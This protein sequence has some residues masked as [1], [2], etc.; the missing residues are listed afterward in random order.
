VAGIWPNLAAE[1]A[2]RARGFELIAGVDEAGRG[3]LA[4]PVVAAAVLLPL[5]EPVRVAHISGVR[6]SKLLTARQRQACF[7]QIEAAADAIGIGVA[8]SWEVDAE[9]I[10]EATRRAMGRAVRSLTPAPEFLLIDHV[11][12]PD[13]CCPQQA[14]VKG[15]RHCLSIAAASIV[16]KVIRDEWMAMLERAW[17]GYGFR[18]HKGYPTAAH[19]RALATLGPCPIHRRTFTPVRS[20]AEG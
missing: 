17:P 4:G 12:L 1:Q 10:V 7:K 8:S 15:D 11:L 19:R 16:A 6:D 13:I 5:D 2:A 18:A 20:L 9:G 3:C 14:I